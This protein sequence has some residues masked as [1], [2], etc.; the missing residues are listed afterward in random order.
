MITISASAHSSGLAQMKNIVVAQVAGGW[1][2]AHDR[3]GF[4][5]EVKPQIAD[6]F[7]GGYFLSS[8][9]W[10]CPSRTSFPLKSGFLSGCFDVSAFSP[11][12]GFGP[13]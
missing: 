8:T 3:R 6:Q 2:W 10:P 5:L 7:R 11:R 12:L 4:E 13:L 9:V 1:E